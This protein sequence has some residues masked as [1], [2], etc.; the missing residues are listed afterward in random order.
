M[1]KKQIIISKQT[2]KRKEEKEN[3]NR[4]NN[5]KKKNSV[6]KQNC[7]M[8]NNAKMKPSVLIHG[9]ISSI[10][11]HPRNNT[12]HHRFTS[13]FKLFIGFLRDIRLVALKRQ[14]DYPKRIFRK[15]SSESWRLV[16]IKFQA[17]EITRKIEG[18]MLTKYNLLA[19]KI[20]QRIFLKN[21]ELLNYLCFNCLNVD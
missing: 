14:Q 18:K 10:F 4:S 16:K 13:Y 12:S 2:I 11:F 8:A 21:K 9:K 5:K 20:R 6:S 1:E 7:F 17:E 19:C 3:D 15:A